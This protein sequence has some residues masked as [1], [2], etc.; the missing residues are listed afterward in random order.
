M[1]NDNGTLAGLRDLLKKLQAD[2][3]DMAGADSVDS[4]DVSSGSTKNYAGGGPVQSMPEMDPNFMAQLNQGVNM[5]P[6]GQAPIPQEAG[7]PP[8]REVASNL[9]SMPDTNYDFYKDLGQDQR[10]ALFQQLQTQKRSPGA[11]VAQ[12]LGGLGDAIANSLG[13]QHTT[14]QN[15]IV[16]D[17]DKRQE[18]ELGA[19]DT[20]RAQK[21]QGMEA[22]EQMKMNDPK[23][24]YAQSLREVLKSKGISAPSGMSASILLKIFPALGEMAYKD[25]TLNLAGAKNAAD[26]DDKRKTR[27]L[28]AAKGL[29]KRGPLD[30]AKEA[31]MGDSEETKV[32]KDELAA[33]E[34]GPQ[35]VSSQAEYDALPSG[36]EYTD[37]TGHTKRKGGR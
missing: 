19:F 11:L 35:L 10:M 4:V 6:P 30:R 26:V 2:K 31:I 12:G 17:R 25:A 24:P 7:A 34:D 27:K 8:L 3:M 22:G 5:T 21:M 23:H 20:Q 36:T 13:G 18:Q 15:D 1:D 28:D 29:S 9:S 16:A 14:F 37:S 33:S 32:Y